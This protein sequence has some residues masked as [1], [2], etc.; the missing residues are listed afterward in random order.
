MAR[1]FTKKEQKA[2]LQKA[3]ERAESLLKF[4]DEYEELCNKYQVCVTRASKDPNT[5]YG[6]FIYLNYQGL[7]S[8]FWNETKEEFNKT[9]K[10]AMKGQLMKDIA[11]YSDW[12]E[13]KK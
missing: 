11:R 3:I 9:T 12:L 10:E 6:Q 8:G 4:C 1:K 13:A 5:G 2:N 7:Y